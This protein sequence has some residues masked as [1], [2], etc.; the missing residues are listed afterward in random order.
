MHGVSRMKVLR[1]T[2]P[3]VRP[4]L[5]F[6]S[7]Q[8]GKRLVFAQPREPDEVCVGSITDRAVTCVITVHTIV[9]H[10]IVIEGDAFLL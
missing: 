10:T 2:D 8:K 1:C 6:H 3:A 5:K 7:C 9:I 4:K